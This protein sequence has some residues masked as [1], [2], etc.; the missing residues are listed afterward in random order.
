MATET[1]NNNQEVD[2]SLALVKKTRSGAVLPPLKVRS[3]LATCASK[4]KSFLAKA[5]PSPPSK[6]W[7]SQGCSPTS[8]E[9]P[10]DASEASAG[11]SD[12]T[13]R[14][15]IV[16]I[17][18]VA[19]QRVSGVGSSNKAVEQNDRIST[20]SYSLHKRSSVWGSF[21]Q[22]HMPHRVS[23]ALRS[24]ATK[25]MSAQPERSQSD[26]DFVFDEKFVFERRENDAKYHEVNIEVSSVA[27]GL[28]RK[29]IL[30]RVV[31]DLDAE[32]A[33]AS[34]PIQRQSALE[35]SDGS[36]S[37]VEIHYVLHRMVVTNAL[38]AAASRVLTR[39]STSINDDD[40][41]DACGQIF[42]DLWYLC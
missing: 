38:A 9:D 24:G 6:L 4:T 20:T 25:K 33:E 22:A 10:T 2:P 8:V 32:F 1:T 35:T 16:E 12:D 7:T 31:V 3:Q 29:H 34:G 13:A 28:G 27:L 37:D 40:D 14:G 11:A 5:F 39:S 17:I 36:Q 41:M 26:G 19:V 18:I 42:P 30:G 21:K 15:E 23:C